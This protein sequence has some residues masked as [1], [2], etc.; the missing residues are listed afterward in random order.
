MK[1]YFLTAALACSFFSCSEDADLVTNELN[2]SVA[3]A[4]K[5]VVDLGFQIVTH[6]G[7]PCVK[8]ENQSSY[9]AVLNEISPLADS[10]REA[11]FSING[12]VSQLRLMKEAIVEQEAIVDNYE[13]D[14][15]QLFPHQQIDAFMEKYADVF[16]FNPYDSTDFIPDY[17]TEVM[18]RS[19]VNRN[20]VFLIGDS[21]VHP[22]ERT[23]EN[24]FGSPI[25]L[26]GDNITTDES[27]LNKAET[28][29]QIPGG[30]YV[31]VRA[32]PSLDGEQW[33]DYKEWCVNFSFELL[34]QKKKVLWKQHNCE[35]IFTFVA[36]TTG[37]YR[38]GDQYI[39]F[40]A[41]NANIP[42]Y[43]KATLG[44]GMFPKNEK[45]SNGHKFVVTGTMAIH[46]NEI[47]N[48]GYGKIDLAR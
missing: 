16:L 43:G 31:K 30:N 44:V 26:L 8:F 38:G 21:L 1:N 13:K 42:W 29:Y 15:T 7:I 37:K 2:E 9:E 27:S 18:Y 4:T 11:T 46:S 10:E 47:P 24:L 3:L 22:T 40:S 14:L 45:L 33:N 19:F 35:I 39:V 34:S 36:N 17:K 5:S 48:I 25:M 28:K 32:I 23:I 6:D 41:N 12:F 20:G